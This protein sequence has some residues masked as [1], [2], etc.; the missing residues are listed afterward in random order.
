MSKKRL[1]ARDILAAAR[2]ESSPLHRYFEWDDAVA[3]AKL[4]EATA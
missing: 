3:A 4:R 1:T 2:S